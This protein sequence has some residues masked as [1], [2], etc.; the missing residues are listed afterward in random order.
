MSV[1]NNINA[2]FREL[3]TLANKLTA[4]NCVMLSSSNELSTMI[5]GMAKWKQTKATT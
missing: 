2:P 1:D 3:S 4:A 5:P